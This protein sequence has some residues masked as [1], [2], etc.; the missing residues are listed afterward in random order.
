MTLY[1]VVLFLQR[2]INQTFAIEDALLRKLQGS[3]PQDAAGY[4]NS[5]NRGTGTLEGA[6]EWYD[7]VGSILNTMYLDSTCGKDS[8]SVYD[9]VMHVCFSVCVCMYVCI[10]LHTYKHTYTYRHD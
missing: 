8:T 4:F 3:L 6:D 7:W 2:D 10:H 1:L 5:D 9:D